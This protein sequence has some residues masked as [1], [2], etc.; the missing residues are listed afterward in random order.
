M[1]RLTKKN[2]GNTP[3]NQKE[4]PYL[5]SAD[6]NDITNKLGKLEDIE[7]ELGIPLE[8]LFKALKKGKVW[9]CENSLWGYSYH[10]VVRFNLN[11][12]I[13]QSKVCS[14][15]DCDWDIDLKDYGKTWA[16]T[17]EELE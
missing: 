3:Y 1:E 8:V 17:S 7:E 2:N 13:L 11:E 5:A 16:L 10:N 4:Y 9:A 6:I 15:S 14:Y 12:V